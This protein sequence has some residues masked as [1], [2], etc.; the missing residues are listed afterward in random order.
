MRNSGGITYQNK[1]PEMNYS[2][3]S[4]LE[5]EVGDKVWWSK[6]CIGTLI[7]QLRNE[8]MFLECDDENYII[9]PYQEMIMRERDG[10]RVG[11]NDRILAKLIF[12]ALNSTLDLSMTSLALH[13]RDEFEVVYTPSFKGYYNNGRDVIE[14]EVGD[15]VKVLGGGRSVGELEDEYNL[16]AGEKLVYF[17]SADVVGVEETI[18]QK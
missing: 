16:E 12:P 8:V 15:R 6:T 14:C 13:I 2:F 3:Q 5:L 9:L 4:E 10:V 18:K 7:K 11:L 1:L 17:R